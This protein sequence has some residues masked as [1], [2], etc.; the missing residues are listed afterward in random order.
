MKK[1]FT[2]IALSVLPVLA[3]ATNYVISTNG[4]SYSPDLVTCKIGDVVAIDGSTVHPLVQ[5][6]KAT[7]NA[8]GNTPMAG[9]W[10]VKTSTYNFTA[11]V[12][13]TIYFVC[14]VHVSLGMK[15]RI[16]VQAAATAV[17]NLSSPLNSIS[18]Y[19]NPVSTQGFLKVVTTKTLTINASIFALDGKLVK[20]VISNVGNI[21]G[22]YSVSFDVHDMMTGEYLMVV[23]ENEQ[24]YSRKFLVVK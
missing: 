23:C 14:Q 7:W 3:N 15:G 9:G 11:T 17:E 16:I 5:V 19:P 8:G 21:N 10:G 6:D 12:A 2:L 22:E 20:Q 13:D 1:Y 24:K 18:L 4:T